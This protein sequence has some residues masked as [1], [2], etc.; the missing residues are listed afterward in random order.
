MANEKKLTIAVDAKVSSSVQSLNKLLDD[1]ATRGNKVAKAFQSVSGVG[2]EGQKDVKAGGLAKALLQEKK[3][4]D[5]LG[6]SGEKLAK[7]LNEQ[8]SKSQTSLKKQLEDSTK[9]LDLLVKKHEFASARVEKL[10]REGADPARLALAERYSGRAGFDLMKGAA[11]RQQMEAALGTVSGAGGAPGGGGGGGGAAGSLMGMLLNRAGVPMGGALMQMGAIGGGAAALAAGAVLGYK[12]SMAGLER[13][14]MTAA[15]L[16]AATGQQYQSVAGF[17]IRQ[18]YGQGMLATG[19]G[20]TGMGIRRGL[21]DF[22][23]DLKAIG[24]SLVAPGY[25]TEIYAASTKE[26]EAAGLEQR[27]ERAGSLANAEEANL[28]RLEQ[29][30][31]A[32]LARQRWRFGRNFF[33]SMN[34]QSAALG[35]KISGMELASYAGGLAPMTGAWSA[36]GYAGRVGAAV[37]AG[38]D[39]AAALAIIGGTAVGGGNPLAYTAGLDPTMRGILGQ[40]VAGT[41]GANTMMFG[42]AGNALADTLAGGITATGGP[43]G[44]RQAQQAVMGAGLYSQVFAGHDPFQKSYNI[45]A[46]S[47]ALAGSG[48]SPYTRNMLATQLSDPKVLS[49]VM[50]NQLPDAFR[51]AGITLDQAQAAARDIDRG[52]VTSRWF[53]TGEKSIAADRMREMREAG[54]PIQWFQSMKGRSAAERERAIREAA[55]LF[56]QVEMGLTGGDVGAGEAMLRRAVGLAS[57]VSAR[58]GR[59]GPGA[60]ESEDALDVLLKEQN[61]AFNATVTNTVTNLDN[62]NSAVKRVAV[63]I[64]QTASDLKL[65]GGVPVPRTAGK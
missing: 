45:A 19:E 2:P 12:M 21:G 16:G 63:G 30:H 55:P 27:I 35:N 46:S 54:G 4:F 39:P 37:T 53:D 1:F 7:I 42:G 31:Q 14:I 5:D 8:V 32:G 47:A 38:M 51:Y 20:R 59:G 11:E 61:R 23:I 25:A 18:M 9:G 41:M 49:A 44:V 17:N 34:A 26:K 50:S 29:Q 6:K 13:P 60:P 3:L 62:L 40:G 48:A 22:L 36:G 65:R 52:L 10:K 57:P 28:A 15:T 58:K 56:A 24:T 64:N 33:E 43:M